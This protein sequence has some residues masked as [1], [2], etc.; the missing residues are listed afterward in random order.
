MP[1][2]RY[3]TERQLML[4][5][6]PQEPHVIVAYVG[7]DVL[8]LLVSRQQLCCAQCRAGSNATGSNRGTADEQAADCTDGRYKRA[9][10]YRVSCLRLEC[11]RSSV[12]PGANPAQLGLYEILIDFLRELFRI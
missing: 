10:R 5:R 4:E 7:L 12:Q 11:L 8:A 6:T 1:C 9:Q 2:A 3:A